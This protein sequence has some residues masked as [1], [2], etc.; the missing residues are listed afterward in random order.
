MQNLDNK[1]MAQ[2]LKLAPLGGRDVAPNP[3]VGAVIVKKGKVIGKGYHQKFGGPH[4]EVN[5]IRSV[6]NQNDLKGATIY[7]TLEPCRHYGKTPPCLDLIEK[8]GIARIVCGSRDP[9]QQNSKSQNP[10]SKKIPNFKIQITKKSQISKSKIT[11]LTGPI[12]KK[13]V[14]LN[15]FFFTWVT[16]KR[17]FVTVKIAM[18]ADGFV[19]GVGG[20]PVRFTNARQDREVHRLRALHQAIMVGTNTVLNDDPQLNV[21]LVEGKDPLR[22]IL[23]PDLR[24]PRNARVFRDDNYLIA[25]TR[26]HDDTTTRHAMTNSKVWVSPTEKHISLKKLFRHLADIGISSVLA[27]T[28][29]TIYSSIKKDGL[30]DELIVYRSKKRLKKGLRL[31]L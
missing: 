30:I 10:K 2:A 26:R 28:G 20:K 19:A 29:P 14:E 18:S 27:E 8:V 16:K 9:F 17:P 13:C 24:I 31:H 21:R 23:D 25:T 7:V 15:K 6:K 12:A 4:A 5:A 22:V 11:F 1:Y 3:M